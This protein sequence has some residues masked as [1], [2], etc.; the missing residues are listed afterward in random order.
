MALVRTVNVTG[1][2]ELPLENITLQLDFVVPQD[3]TAVNNISFSF[4]KDNVYVSGMYEGNGFTYYNVNDGIATD[5]L[6]TAVKD[7]LE[8]IIVEYSEI[9]K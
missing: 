9:T 7:K 2:V 5:E 4:N 8:E 6:M 3:N 1:T